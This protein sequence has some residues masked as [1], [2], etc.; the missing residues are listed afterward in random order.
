MRELPAKEAVM[1][2]VCAWC[3]A[4]VGQ[5]GR[6]NGRTSHTVCDRCLSGLVQTIDHATMPASEYRPGPTLS[7]KI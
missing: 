7:L 1:D 5:R 6:E 4:Q 2:I 3:R